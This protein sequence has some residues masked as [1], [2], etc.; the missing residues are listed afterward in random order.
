MDPDQY[1]DWQEE[2]YDDDNESSSPWCPILCPE[3]RLRQNVRCC[4]L[5]PQYA[6]QTSLVLETLSTGR[7]SSSFVLVDLPIRQT[8]SSSQPFEEQYHT[9]YQEENATEIVP[10]EGSIAPAED[11]TP[12]HYINDLSGHMRT[13]PDLSGA[14][15]QFPNSMLIPQI[16]ISPVEPNTQYSLEIFEQQFPFLPASDLVQPY[17]TPQILQNESSCNMSEH[18][19][20]LDSGL[21]APESSL[22]TLTETKQAD[23]EMVFDPVTGQQHNVVTRRKS[24]RSSASENQHRKLIRNRG[25]QCASCKKRKRRVSRNKSFHSCLHVDLRAVQSFS[26]GL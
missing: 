14:G 3:R 22:N 16:H 7:P 6:H 20:Q 25:G 18:N 9:R 2:R 23:H 15:R 1:L 17:Q 12:T 10:S 13:D 4:R 24:R 21:A 19:R 11:L 26:F 5:D 8:A